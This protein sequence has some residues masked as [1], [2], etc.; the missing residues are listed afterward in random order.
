MVTIVNNY[1][2]IIY[3]MKF[4]FNRNLKIFLN[5]RALSATKLYLIFSRKQIVEECFIFG[6]LLDVHVT[7]CISDIK[8]KD[9][10][11]LLLNQVIEP[12]L[13]IMGL[14]KSCH[15]EK[16]ISLFPIFSPTIM[17]FKAVFCRICS[18]TL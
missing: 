13:L 3:N 12:V 6:F 18:Y 17:L 2:L 7:L 14:W 8:I 16:S 5:I 15:L 10:F 9:E 4:Y 1:K 11:R